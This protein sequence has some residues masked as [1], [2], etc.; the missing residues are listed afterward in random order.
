VLHLNEKLPI[1]C[2]KKCCAL[3]PSCPRLSVAA[4]HA[5][6]D[7]GKHEPQ[8]YYCM[9]TPQNSMLLSEH[10]AC[11]P[12][13]H[14][15]L[16]ELPTRNTSRH[17]IRS[18][19]APSHAELPITCPIEM[20]CPASIVPTLIG[21]S[22]TCYAG[23]RKRK[24]QHNYCMKHPRN[25]MLLSEHG[26]CW[27]PQHHVLGELPTIVRCTRGPSRATQCRAWWN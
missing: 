22:I 14:H 19:G 7:Q 21:G 10:G 1:T 27:P 5:M 4:S 23:P 11:W 18:G 3:H 24:P 26:A 8:L 6:Q 13:Q 9:K 12:P 16:G 15:V 2:P 25:S 17:H 20:L